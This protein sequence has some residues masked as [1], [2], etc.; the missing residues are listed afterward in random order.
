MLKGWVWPSRPWQRVHIDFTGPIGGDTY[1][2]LVD[3]HS[4][5]PDVVDMPS[6]T[7]T[8]TIE[9]LQHIFASYGLP[10]QLVSDNGPQFSSEEFNEFLVHNGIKHLCSA[11]YDPATNG[12]LSIL[13]SR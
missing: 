9:A 6:T 12:W 4:K 3:A 13:F 10:L 11:P 2:V 5:L 7:S 1:L 8:K